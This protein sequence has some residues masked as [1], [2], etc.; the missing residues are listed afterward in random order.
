MPEDHGIN[1]TT[2]QGDV[3]VL[4]M[5]DG[6]TQEGVFAKTT[7]DVANIGSEAPQAPPTEI[8]SMLTK[9]QKKIQENTDLSPEDKNFA[10]QQLKALERI[11]LTSSNDS[12]EIMEATSE[13]ENLT[14]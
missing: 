9:L 7:G 2:T 6:I 14:I 3:I 4:A 11:Q 8:Q 1:L 10:L 13:F 5:G 12:R